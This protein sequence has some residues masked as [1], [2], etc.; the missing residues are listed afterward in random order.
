M[1]KKSKVPT[2]K[3]K[4]RKGASGVMV[5]ANTEVYIDG[6]KM[7]NITG[8]ELTI[9]A[10]SVAKIKMEMVGKFEFEGNPV[11]EKTTKEKRNG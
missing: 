6:K 8:L 4:Q 1:A 11:L 3:I 2:I 7:N 5:G 10:R 9:G